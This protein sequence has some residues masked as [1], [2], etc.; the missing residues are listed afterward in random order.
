[1]TTTTICPMPKVCT[2]MTKAQTTPV[3]CK[4]TNC[5]SKYSSRSNLLGWWKSYGNE[6]SHW[7]RM[8]TTFLS[9]TAKLYS[10][11]RQKLFSIREKALTYLVLF[12]FV[13]SYNPSHLIA[14]VPPKPVQ[15][16]DNRRPGRTVS[17]L[18]CM[19]GLGPAGVPEQSG[20]HTNRGV[21]GPYALNIGASARQRRPL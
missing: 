4:V 18:Q 8:S 1:M 10:R 12:S 16:D 3:R 2:T 17:H 21:D 6:R 19:A 13:Q 14:A 11:S 5:P 7:P 20:C 15:C 9:I